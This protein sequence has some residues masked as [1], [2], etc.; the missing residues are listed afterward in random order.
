M[1]GLF[2]EF[3][4]N[5][6]LE[7]SPSSSW[8]MVALNTVTKFDWKSCKDVLDSP[9]ID[10]AGGQEVR[11]LLDPSKP[12]RENNGSVIQHCSAFEGGDKNP[13]KAFWL[14]NL[15]AFF[16]Y[17]SDMIWVA[18]FIFLQNFQQTWTSTWQSPW[19]RQSRWSRRR[20]R[21]RLWRS[22]GASP[23]QTSCSSR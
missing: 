3:L 1:N 7:I 15:S 5:S 4:M 11:V 19:S 22:S 12:A 17:D 2:M 18:S 16:I 23:R 14:T 9:D 6:S 13:G 21:Q 20:L 10:D 8:S